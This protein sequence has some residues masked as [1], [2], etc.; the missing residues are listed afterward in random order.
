MCSETSHIAEKEETILPDFPVFQMS[1]D[2]FEGEFF[3]SSIS[4]VALDSVED[5]GDL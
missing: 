4:S 1:Q 5:D 2:G 3:G